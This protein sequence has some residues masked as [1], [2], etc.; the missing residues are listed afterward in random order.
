MS[1][2]CLSIFVPPG[3]WPSPMSPAG[4][5]LFQHALQRHD[6]GVEAAL[7]VVGQRLLGIGAA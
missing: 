6:P 3:A 1:L 4:L 5:F 7:L 2:T